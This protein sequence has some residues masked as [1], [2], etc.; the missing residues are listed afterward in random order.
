[1]LPV[2]TL[3]PPPPPLNPLNPLPPCPNVFAPAPA[4]LTILGK[5]EEIMNLAT[6]VQV[7]ISAASLIDP[8][9]DDELPV[10]ARHGRQPM[11]VPIYLRSWIYPRSRTSKHFAHMTTDYNSDSIVV[12]GS[13]L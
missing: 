8:E 10:C 11:E 12:M 13:Y 2:L 9:T 5:P 6:S 4:Q 3:A 1:M 7:D